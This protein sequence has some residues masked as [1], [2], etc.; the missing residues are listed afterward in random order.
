MRGM[1]GGMCGRQAEPGAPRHPKRS[2]PISPAT[3]QPRATSHR[4]RP[5]P[6]AGP[7]G[8]RYH[9]TAVLAGEPAVT[10]GHHQAAG[11]GKFRE[12]DRERVRCRLRLWIVY[13]LAVALGF[14]NLG[15]VI[16]AAIGLALCFARNALC[17][18]A[19]LISLVAMRKTELFPAKR[20]A[21]QK[22]QVRQ[23]LR[24]VQIDPR[25]ANPARHDRGD[26]HAGPGVPGDAAAD[27]QPG[28]PPRGRRLRRDGLGDRALARSSA[29]CPPW[30][31]GSWPCPP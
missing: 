3:G 8:D 24:Y 26:R 18:G 28:V 5:G 11:G 31:A 20:V 27:G 17:Y 29:A 23:G 30:P 13:L 14:V 6:T 1:P 10:S 21:R 15:G 12:I 2:F 19:V 9:L 7:A 16:A 25:A 22:R 4:P